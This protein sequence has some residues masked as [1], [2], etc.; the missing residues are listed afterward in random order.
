MTQ[1]L[2]FGVLGTGNIAGQFAQGTAAAQRCK[3]TAV[4][5]RSLESARVFATKYQI[6]SAHGSYEALLHDDN[7]DAVYVSLPNCLHH[8]WTIKALQAGKHVL[9]EK[10]LAMNQTQAREMFDAARQ[11]QRVLIEAFMYLC[12]PLTHAWLTKIR[13]GAIGRVKFVRAG[14]CY[15]ASKEQGNVRFDKQLGG[16]VLMD[17]GCYCLSVA[18]LLG[19]GD[20]TYLEATAQFDDHGVDVLTAGTLHFHNGV[21]ASFHCG[22]K[23][24]ADNTLMISG[25]KGCLLVPI[26]WKPPMQGATFTIMQS[27]PPKMDGGTSQAPPS[28]PQTISIDAGKPLYGLEADAFAD[29]V[30]DGVQ[31][32]VTAEQSMGHMRMLDTLREKIGLRW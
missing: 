14:F 25:D 17:V 8:E 19:E 5:S 23:V 21:M 20:P 15:F 2:R 12:H 13:E 27:I 31:P 28:G 30:L 11:H 24:H 1:P 6:A 18:R 16:G 10:P 9:C 29:C 26:P 7:I 4:G 32:F 3:V 22:M